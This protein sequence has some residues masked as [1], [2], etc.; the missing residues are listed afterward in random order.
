V[1][2]SSERL[3]DAEGAAAF[4]I[5]ELAAGPIADGYGR[6]PVLLVGL[7]VLAVATVVVAASPTWPV[8]LAARVGQ[9]AAAGT[10]APVALTWVSEAL[11]AQRRTLGLG[12]VVTAYQASAITGQL[13]GQVVGE[14]IGW[15]WVYLLLAVFYVLVT[16]ILVRRLYEPR[17]R[18][19]GE[20]DGLVLV[21]SILKLL[22]VRLLLAAWLLGSLLLAAI[23]AVY[24]GM[25]VHLPP[26][27]ARTG[28]CWCGFAPSG[29]WGYWPFQWCSGSWATEIR[30]ASSSPGSWSVSSDCSPR[31]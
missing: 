25:Q 8:Y 21:R 9:G 18:V 12:I 10:F 16:V 7:A 1:Q 30:W 28:T 4:A 3:A 31:P 17:Q 23:F 27:S 2:R 22:R 11:P 19:P 15:R 6:R 5:G 14:A 26:A 29:C 13:Y 20:T 24:G